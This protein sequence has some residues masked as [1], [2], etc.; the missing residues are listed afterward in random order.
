MRNSRDLQECI[1]TSNLVVLAESDTRLFRHREG[2][3]ADTRSS[4][5]VSG[6]MGA[7][8]LALQF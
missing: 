1:L 6:R 2:I 5:E 7:T 3:L 4:A 8:C